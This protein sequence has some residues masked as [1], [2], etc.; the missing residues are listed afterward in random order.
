MLFFYSGVY[1][2]KNSGKTEKQ[3]KAPYWPKDIETGVALPLFRNL[4]TRLH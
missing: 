1:G 4:A 3:E 2:R